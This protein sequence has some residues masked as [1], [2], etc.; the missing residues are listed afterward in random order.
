MLKYF[1]SILVM[2]S[3][4]S[5]ASGGDK[6][7]TP[8]LKEGSKY[9]YT[10]QVKETSGSTAYAFVQYAVVSNE[11][12]KVYFS[13][14]LNLLKTKSTLGYITDFSSFEY[15]ERKDIID[16]LSRKFTLVVTKK[17]GNVYAEDQ[18]AKKSIDELIYHTSG[19][20]LVETIKLQLAMLAT[21]VPMNKYLNNIGPISFSTDAT[22]GSRAQLT[23]SANNNPNR[24]VKKIIGRAIIDQDTKQLEKMAV[25]FQIESFG[26]NS[27]PTTE[28]LVTV[29]R[30]QLDF[31]EL[32]EG[33]YMDSNDYAVIADSAYI[34]Y[35]S[36]NELIKIREIKVRLPK[37]D[38]PLEKEVFPVNKGSFSADKYGVYLGYINKGNK[39][40]FKYN[41][42][43][44]FDKKNK[45]IKLKL[46]AIDGYNF[47]PLMWGNASKLLQSI[48]RIKA[49]AS[50]YPSTTNVMQVTLN[51]QKKV[52]VADKDAW[53]E[54]APYPEEPNTY[55]V[56]R[57]V[58]RNDRVNL[59]FMEGMTEGAKITLHKEKNVLADWANERFME[60]FLD[61]TLNDGKMRQYK[62]VL[63]DTPTKPIKFY[64]SHVSETPLYEKEIMFIPFEQYNSDKKLPSLT[65][66]I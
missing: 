8:Q 13:V 20:S 10:L 47:Y 57:F 45:P 5:L 50:F 11:N 21:N 6:D 54:F 34:S 27:S 15:D 14:K 26:H 18:K 2:L 9:E 42:I 12:D 7:I 55:I 32:I 38:K 22:D 19:Y 59:W 64:V 23:F 4:S 49:H 1:I 43:R 44:L 66:E 48:N 17:M 40:F 41:N 61:F 29:I 60:I 65:Q 39:G 56:T 36:Q 62:L 31:G 52:R 25:I 3:F 53:V 24:Y 28:A 51:P 37:N 33:Q 35:E 16:R 46:L 63:K 30:G 58:K